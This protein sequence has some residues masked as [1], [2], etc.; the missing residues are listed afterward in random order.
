VLHVLRKNCI[1]HVPCLGEF[2]SL[3]DAVEEGRNNPSW[4]VAC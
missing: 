3:F 1:S 4:E 2:L